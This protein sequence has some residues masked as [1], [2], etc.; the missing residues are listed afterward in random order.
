MPQPQWERNFPVREYNYTHTQPQWLDASPVVS[1]SPLALARTCASCGQR[2]ELCKCRICFSCQKSMLLRRHH[3]RKCWQAVCPDCR[4]KVRYV[5]MLSEPMK[6]CDGCALP[7]G[8]VTL[9]RAK[10]HDHLWG[11]YVLQRA[12]EMPNI[13][14][15]PSCSTQSYHS[16]CPQCG[17]PTIT[18]RL[19]QERVICFGARGSVKTT[20]S[21]KY[22]EAREFALR[23]AAVDECSAREMERSFRVWFPRFQE[24]FAFPKLSC[25]AE[26]QHL[27]L[28]VVSSAV[29]YEYGNFPNLLMSHSDVPYAR[30]L[31][32]LRSTSRYSVFEAPGKVKFITFPGTH[33]YRTFAVNMRCGR[34][35]RQV[36]S[37]LID[38]ATALFDTTN[39]E[40]HR[41]CGG[42][43]LLWE[44]YVHQGFTREADEAALP[45]E[46]LASDVC[47]NGYRLVLSGHSLG[48]A[49][50]QL[51]AIRMLRAYP[52]IFKDNLKCISI[53]A[54][55]IGNY[56]L[57]QCVERWWVAI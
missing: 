8:I 56:Q 24:I 14:I 21:V 33:N 42:V 48:G 1:R 53:G 6:V 50:A 41:V 2:K 54:P 47:Q 49:V 36:W 18:T 43:R 11:L 12:T 13:C 15:A 32:L 38:G 5:H 23:C 25:A 4:E 51:V 16:V 46:Q 34:I 28:S 20:D 9:C 52:G 40:F 3:C 57:A 30:L 39:A 19:H 37:Q 55:L 17:L 10:G 29:A 35:R 44:D 27:L 7:R 45:I 31:K 26:A 22:L